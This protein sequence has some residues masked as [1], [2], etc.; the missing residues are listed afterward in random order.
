M[1]KTFLV[2]AILAGLCSVAI[3]GEDAEGVLE[4]GGYARNLKGGSKQF[5]GLLSSWQIKSEAFKDVFGEEFTKD[6]LGGAIE[7]EFSGANS[8]RSKSGWYTRSYEVKIDLGSLDCEP[9]AEEVLDEVFELQRAAIDNFYKESVEKFQKDVGL[10]KEKVELAKV[11]WE[12][13]SKEYA[14]LLITKPVPSDDLEGYISKL[15][16]EIEEMQYDIQTDE[17]KLEL[18]SKRKSNLDRDVNIKIVNDKVARHLDQLVEIEKQNAGHLEQ[19][20]KAGV[21]SQEAALK[22]QKNLI[23]AKIELAK[24]Q[25]QIQLQLQPE[26]LGVTEDISELSMGVPLK[27]LALERLQQQQQVAFDALGYI[28]EHEIVKLEVKYSERR[29]NEAID[30]VYDAQDFLNNIQPPTVVAVVK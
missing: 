25:E 9:L 5:D 29:F 13:K 16:K 4:V 17:K 6:E 3:A 30:L 8:S 19:K 11:Q 22:A 7:I 24:R 2:I 27:K 28:Q 21:E 20:L 18:L 23:K 12:A 15:T 10:L 1:R 26:I 14:R